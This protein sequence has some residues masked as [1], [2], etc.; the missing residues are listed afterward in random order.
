MNP[1]A[2]QRKAIDKHERFVGG[3]QLSHQ[4]QLT[5]ALL[6]IGHRADRDDHFV[7]H[8]VARRNLPEKD[9]PQESE[10]PPDARPPPGGHWL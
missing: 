7:P 2:S 5:Q 4:A 9:E 3:G 6:G 10:R 1:S 8:A